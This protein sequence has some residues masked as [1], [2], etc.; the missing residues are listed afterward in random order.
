MTAFL[1]RGIFLTF[2]LALLA[3]FG[4]GKK[5]LDEGTPSD[6]LALTAQEQQV[7]QQIGNGIVYFEYDRYDLRSESKAVLTQ[8][9]AIIKQYPQLRV[10]IEGHCDERGT[11]EYNLAL[12]E[13]RARAAYDF[14]VGLGVSPGQLEMISYGKLHP[15]VEGHSEAAWAKNRRDEFRVFKPRR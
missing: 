2:A 8:K 5:G 14:L 13:R 11:E 12:G 9:A 15:A 3:G 4:C 7:A 6:E 10:T 1:R